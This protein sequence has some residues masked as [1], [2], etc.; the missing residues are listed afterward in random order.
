M[1]L[2]NRFCVS[3]VKNFFAS[4]ALVC[5]AVASFN[6][7]DSG[8]PKPDA[9]SMASISG[10]VTIDGKPVTQ[11]SDIAFYC[12]DKGATAAGKIDALGKFSLS[13]ADPKIGIPAGRYQVMIRPP[14]PPAM[15]I[16]T[17][18]YKKMMSGGAG[19]S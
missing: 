13:A 5:A 3:G 11:D 2:F 15:Q 16:G 10:S 14:A 7:C 18:D 6:G 9:S 8:P 12:P 17:D 1:I 19:A 4:A